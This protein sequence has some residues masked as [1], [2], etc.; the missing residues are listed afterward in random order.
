LFLREGTPFFPVGPVEQACVSLHRIKRPPRE[1]GPYF[2][3]AM[4]AALSRVLLTGFFLAAALLSPLAGLLI[5][6][7]GFLLATLAALL[8][9]ALTR[10]LRLLTTLVLITHE[11]L[12]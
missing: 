5:R 10:L 7:A 11:R 6:L 12:L 2:V 9:A 8:L 3:L 1:R 4:L